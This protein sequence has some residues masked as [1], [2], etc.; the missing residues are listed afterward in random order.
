MVAPLGMTMDM[1]M[2]GVMFAPTD[3]LTLIVM[4]PFLD[5]EMNHVTRLGRK[6]STE[7]RGL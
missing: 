2:I 3:K 7:S 1:H 6:F 4:A 5:I